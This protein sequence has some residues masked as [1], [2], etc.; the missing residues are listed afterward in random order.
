MSPDA[1]AFKVER[2]RQYGATVLWSEP[3]S[4]A[5]RELAEHVAAEQ[6]LA[7]IPPYDHRDILLGQGSIGLEIIEQTTPSTV[8]VPIGGGGLIAG[9]A[10]A[11][12]L[13][14][15]AIR[16]IGVE[17]AWEND[18][19]QSRQQDRLVALPAASKSI[20]DAIRVQA[21]GDLPYHVIREF[22]DEIVTVSEEQIA[23]AT[24]NDWTRRICCSNHRVL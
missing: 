22:V 8:F 15:P 5:R 10:L 12:K 23:T 24:L 3:T 18:A 21:L 17:P 11:I 2:T 20:A 4:Q 6:Q 1:P 7:L 16:V 13:S 19:W 14:N 9:I